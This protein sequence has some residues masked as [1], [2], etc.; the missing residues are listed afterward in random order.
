MSAQLRRDDSGVAIVAAIAVVG[1]VS[2]LVLLM[3]SVGIVA[4]R[5]SAGDRSRSVGVASVDGLVDAETTAVLQT[6][7]PTALPCSYNPG[8]PIN[9]GPDQTTTN[10]TIKYVNAAGGYLPTGVGTCLPAGCSPS[11][12]G[13]AV[14]TATSSK[15]G[16]ANALRTVETYGQPHPHLLQPGKPGQGDLR[17]RR[18]NLFQQRRHP[19]QLRTGC[20]HLQ[21]EAPS[22]A[23]TL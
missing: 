5:D 2:T 16:T 3:V 21:R 10:V 13:G 14:I 20:R 11:S 22:T 12:I 18:R 19:R 15:P 23:P 1:I 8:T 6:A 9:T 4:A 17:E 7:Q